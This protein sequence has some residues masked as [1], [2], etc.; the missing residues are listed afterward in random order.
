ML[1]ALDHGLGEEKF[2]D[3]V[4]FTEVRPLP[5]GAAATDYI[6]L[7]NLEKF[8]EWRDSRRGGAGVTARVAADGA[9]APPLN[10]RSLDGR[11]RSSTRRSIQCPASSRRSYSWRRQATIR[12]AG[13]PPQVTV[14][15]FRSCSRLA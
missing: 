6:P 5:P 14:S 9:C 2:A 7:R 10:A 3:A 8:I 13:W 4:Q 1:R 15:T 12:L 11:R